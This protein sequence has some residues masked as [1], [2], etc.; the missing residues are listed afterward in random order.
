M[1]LTPF[2]VLGAEVVEDLAHQAD[3]L[4]LAHAGPQEAVQLLVSGVHQADGRREQADLVL[5]LEAPRVQEGLLAVDDRHAGR[6]ERGQHGQLDDV[7]AER[8]VGETA[9]VELAPDLAGDVSGDAGPR[10][11]GPPQR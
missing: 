2:D 9:L 11:E 7:H 3:A 10:V 6:L 1:A 5:G 8:L 4:V